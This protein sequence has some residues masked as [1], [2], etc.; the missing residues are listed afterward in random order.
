[1][2]VLLHDAFASRKHGK[3]LKGAV[4]GGLV[5]PIKGFFVACRQIWSCMRTRLGKMQMEEARPTWRSMREKP[6]VVFVQ[7]FLR[8]FR[9]FLKAKIHNATNANVLQKRERLLGGVTTS[10]DALGNPAQH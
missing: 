5:N 10:I 2:A 6:N 1:V 7:K 4:N 3:N 9:V 8:A